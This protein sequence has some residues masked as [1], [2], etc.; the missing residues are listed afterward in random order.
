MSVKLEVWS[1]LGRAAG[2]LC[3]ALLS[4]WTSCFPSLHNHPQPPE[5]LQ[6]LAVPCPACEGAGTV[7]AVSFPPWP[8]LGPFLPYLL[9]GT[10]RLAGI[11]FLA[12]LPSVCFGG[13]WASQTVKEAELSTVTPQPWLEQG[14]GKATAP[15]VSVPQPGLLPLQLA[16]CFR[17]SQEP[18]S[19][20]GSPWR[21]S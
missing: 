19:M 6:I 11:P 13:R 18:A 20:V 9:L 21:R 3:R 17:L 5:V 15:C 10:P 14:A 7:A 16:I 4:L 8:P 2:L 12:F 1:P